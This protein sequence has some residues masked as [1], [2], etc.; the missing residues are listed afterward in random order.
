MPVNKEAYIRY[1]IIDSCICNSHKPF[2]SMDE[3][4]DACEEKLGKSFTI[5]TIQK[6]IKTMKE[7][8]ALGFM[9]PVKFSKM[10]NGY[11]YTDKDY[12]IRTVPLNEEEV[13]ALLAA[14]DLLST[15][16]GER[17][18]LNFNAAVDKILASVK[19]KY[20]RTRDK[21]I[22]I[23]TENA[24]KQRGWEYFDLFFKAAKERIPVSFLH[25]S[26][27]KRRFNSII[28][29]PYLLKEF[30]NKWYII[31]YSEN[32]KEI[33]SFGMDRVMEPLFLKRTFLLKKGF[34]PEKHMK[35][36]YGVFPLSNKLET[37]R[38]K[39]APA[40]GNYLLSQ[41]IHDSQKVEIYHNYGHLT[42][43][44]KLIPSVELLNQF[45]M[46]SGQLSVIEPE[47]V[48]RAIKKSLQTAI[49]NEKHL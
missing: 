4:I 40:I 5:S 21:K 34:D 43:S 2:P 19:E 25:F 28:F 13:D 10:H 16:S 30:Q 24:P 33:R 26:Y 41:P 23:Q 15:F 44:L 12:T 42:L 36:I 35:E 31:G 3:L 37:I 17:V 9:A 20:E 39:V 8:E 1:K 29:H 49:T 22:I 47:W 46:H 18:S 38:F 14:V 27:F 7:D 6:D 32:H 11:Y 48:K 45:L